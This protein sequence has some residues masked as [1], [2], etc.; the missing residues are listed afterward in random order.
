MGLNTSTDLEPA[1]QFFAPLYGLEPEAASWAELRTREMQKLAFAA[2][3][4]GGT[5]QFNAVAAPEMVE[6]DVLKS[7]W[8]DLDHLL[9]DPRLA[10]IRNALL[11][12]SGVYPHPY[13]MMNFDAYRTR[14]AEQFGPE[15]TLD[16]VFAQL[17]RDW[18]EGLR[19]RLG[20]PEGVSRDELTNAA[21]GFSNADKPGHL[22]WDND[23][24]YGVPAT[25]VKKWQAI[26]GLRWSLEEA[27]AESPLAEF[28]PLIEYFSTMPTEDRAREGRHGGIEDPRDPEQVRVL[29]ALLEQTSWETI[30]AEEDRSKRN[31]I[32]RRWPIAR[33]ASWQELMT[34]FEA[35]YN[36]TVRGRERVDMEAPAR[37]HAEVLRVR[38][39]LRRALM[40]A[41][42]EVPHDSG[43]A[44]LFERAERAAA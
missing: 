6:A 42:G 26:K 10:P 43:L 44:D 33:N 41:Q 12:E 14:L 22:G 21:I 5:P 27:P 40:A 29:M 25:Y 3:Y 13:P 24:D 32:G 34:M 11:G 4:P 1:R 15:A 8:I 20:L 30:D 2:K 36:E 39:E 18:L 16:Q 38:D 9:I 19:T 37:N 23:L 17:H 31:D 7:I 28:I 35:A